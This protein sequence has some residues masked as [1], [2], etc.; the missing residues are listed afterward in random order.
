VPAASVR[1]PIHSGYPEEHGWCE[2]AGAGDCG[3]D[4][5]SSAP[6]PARERMSVFSLS[7]KS[8]VLFSRSWPSVPILCHAA[9][10]ASICHLLTLR[11]VRLIR[12]AW[13]LF[14]AAF[15]LVQHP[16]THARFV[17]ELYDWSR[18][19]HDD[20]DIAVA[21]GRETIRSHHSARERHSGDILGAISGCCPS[22][23]LGPASG[24]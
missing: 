24:E 7:W 18:V 11:L 6:A 3:Q 5:G 19:S 2:S 10:C 21:Q 13:R 16:S 12:N 4:C 14:V 22:A 17:S 15:F 9:L 20:V 23:A 1:F 8:R